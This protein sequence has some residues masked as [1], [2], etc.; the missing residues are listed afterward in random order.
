[1]Q[2]RIVSKSPSAVAEEGLKQILA[3]A[4]GYSHSFSY[5]Y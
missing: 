1:M 4:L 5:L 3:E 2:H